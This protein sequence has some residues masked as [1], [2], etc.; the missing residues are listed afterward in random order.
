MREFIK[1]S[2]LVTNIISF[3]CGF[4]ITVFLFICEFFGYDK[5]NDF[6]KKI[7]F[8]LNHNG[9]IVVLLICVAILIISIFLRKKYF[10]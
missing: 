6:L 2:L 7:R 5:G 3:G 9:L 10:G 8:P 4:I 1:N